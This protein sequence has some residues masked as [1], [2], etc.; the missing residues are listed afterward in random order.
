MMTMQPLISTTELA[1]RLDEVVLNDIRWDLTDPNYGRHTYETGHVPGAVFVDLDT[2]LASESG[3]GRHPLP[4]PSGFAETLGRLGIGAADEV[5]VY[6]DMKNTVSARM[7]WMLRSIGHERVRVLDGGY[8]RWVD[9]GRPVDT[10]NV[11]RNGTTYPKVEFTG[12]ATRHQLEDRP[13]IDARASARYRGEYEPI[14]PKAGHIP[15]AINIPATGNTAEDG[16]FLGSNDLLRRFERIG[17]NTVVSCGSG[18]NACHNALAMV[19]AGLEM[20]EVYV[21]SFSEWSNLD[22][23]ISI[24]ENP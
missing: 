14:D 18:V 17:E 21:G 8:Q 6:D 9:E 5:V 16:R 10:G 23:P 2:D 4:D 22:L 19:L 15:A 20:P 24:G 3:P 7:W 12:V 13:H 1:E 11:T